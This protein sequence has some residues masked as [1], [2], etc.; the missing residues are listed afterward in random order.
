MNSSLERFVQNKYHY[1]PLATG[2]PAV[3]SLPAEFGRAFVV[4][5]LVG[6]DLGGGC[7]I[8]VCSK[9]IKNLLLYGISW[10]S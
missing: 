8:T 6:R 10:V 7:G 1:L 4:P 3:L 9:Q 5:A 2:G